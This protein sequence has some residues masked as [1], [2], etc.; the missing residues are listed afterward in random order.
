MVKRLD[1]NYVEDGIII[2]LRYHYDGDGIGG[3]RELPG[4][5]TARGLPYY[6][7]RPKQT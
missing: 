3:D 6:N 4:D 1:N 7:F 2:E 5:R